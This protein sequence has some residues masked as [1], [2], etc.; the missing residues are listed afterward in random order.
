[1]LHHAGI[2]LLWGANADSHTSS[3]ET[4]N[5]Q[6]HIYLSRSFVKISEEQ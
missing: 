1:M 4:M 2:P 3:E 6:V 5:A